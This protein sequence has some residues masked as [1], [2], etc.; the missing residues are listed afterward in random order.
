MGGKASDHGIDVTA[1]VG[2]KRGRELGRKSLR[3]QHS[4]DKDLIRPMGVLEPKSTLGVSHME[5][6]GGRCR[7]RMNERLT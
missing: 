1:G 2:D 3:L 5:A 7:V 4:P 6:T